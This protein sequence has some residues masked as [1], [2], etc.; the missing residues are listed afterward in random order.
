M[1]DPGLA[2]HR[3]VHLGQQGGRHLDEVHATLVAGRSEAGH[4][5]DHPAAESDQGG[6]P[7][8]PGLEQTVEDQL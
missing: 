7:I 8:M 4:V 3:G 2:A 1:V 6:A 5:A